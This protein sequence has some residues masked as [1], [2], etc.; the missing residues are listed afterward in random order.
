MVLPPTGAISFQDVNTEIRRT[1]TNSL[2]LNDATV[3]KLA[4]VSSG[5]I[6]MSN[7]R[8]KSIVR[9]N[10]NSLSSSTG[11]G[12]GI[13]TTSAGCSLSF[14]QGGIL[15]ASAQFIDGTTD[16]S[17]SFIQEFNIGND[18]QIR[19]EVIDIF[20]GGTGG[21]GGGTSGVDG[22]F[23]DLNT[24]RSFGVFA[25][26]GAYEDGSEPITGFISALIRIQIRHKST[27]RIAI[28]KD[29]SFNADNSGVSFVPGP[30]PGEPQF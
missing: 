1:P 27:Q 13:P 23:Q 16:D 12:T 30:T 22:N 7:L 24:V 28:T 15:S 4:G 10:V 25:V 21:G 17:W 5:A 29:V 20:S 8:G 11:D 14:N 3:R 6:G 2:N 19:S 9:I 18:Y 26:G